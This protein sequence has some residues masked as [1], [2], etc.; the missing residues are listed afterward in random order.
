MRVLVLTILLF[1]SCSA[2]SQVFDNNFE[3]GITGLFS[4]RNLTNKNVVTNK[5]TTKTKPSFSYGASIGYSRYFSKHFFVGTTFGYN[6]F[7]YRTNVNY[8]FNPRQPNDP[9]IPKDYRYDDVFHLLSLRLNMGYSL[10]KNNNYA[11]YIKTGFGSSTLVN[12]VINLL[13]DVNNSPQYLP[14][15]KFEGNPWNQY[16]TLG[17]GSSFAISNRSAINVDLEY[18]HYMK[19]YTTTPEKVRL[20]AA[21]IYCGYAFKL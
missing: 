5:G 7:A 11:V 10:I 18:L 21:S 3:A 4:F 2:F 9:L 13:D 8:N 15:K 19:D 1:F 16:I 12:Y 14:N 20:F 17:V 6:R